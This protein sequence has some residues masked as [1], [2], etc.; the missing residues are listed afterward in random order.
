MG[1]NETESFLFFSHGVK[2]M[3]GKSNE[4][5]FKCATVPRQR[6]RLDRPVQRRD[7]RRYGVTTVEKEV[8]VMNL[9]VYL[10]LCV[11]AC[12]C[13]CVCVSVCASE[14]VCIFVCKCVSESV[15]IC[16]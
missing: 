16:V 10:C 7:K 5:V 9:C 13:M 2:Q 11:C 15:C 1:G 6:R 3:K 4:N 8:R 14:C 12:E